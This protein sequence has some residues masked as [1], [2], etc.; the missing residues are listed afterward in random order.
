METALKPVLRRKE[1]APIV[2]CARLYW[3]FGWP[4][5]V[6]LCL[7]LAAVM[8]LA[9][10]LPQW[11]TDYESN[12]VA[13]QASGEQVRSIAAEGATRTTEVRLPPASDAPR[14]L[15]R[16]QSAAVE[17]GLGWPRAEYQ[18][19]DATDDAPARIEVQCSLKGSYIGIRRFV[20]AILQD[21]P[22]LNL[23]EFRLSR[24]NST[25]GDVDAKIGMV[26]FLASESPSST[27]VQR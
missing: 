9:V 27:R 7:L 18:F 22:T 13:S 12:V 16:I 17:A 21:T 26:V 25:A 19:S 23:R 24:P 11:R 20:T 5:I 10:V 2:A 14:L 15:S 1:A 3:H 8:T 4:G 6:G